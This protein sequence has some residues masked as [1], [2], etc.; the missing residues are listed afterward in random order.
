MVT[1]LNHEEMSQALRLCY[2][3]EQLSKNAGAFVRCPAV[4]WGDPGC[5]KTSLARALAVE[6]AEDFR[7]AGHESGFWATALALKNPEDIGGFPI[8]DKETW[9][10][11]FIP[12]ADLPFVRKDGTAPYGVWV[13]DDLDRAS[14]ETRNCAMSYLLDRT[15]NGND[16]SPNVYLC[17]T[18][19]GESDCGT[20]SPLGGAFGNRL[21][22]LYLRAAEGWSSH[23]KSRHI[24]SI[25]ALLPIKETEF[26]EV[27][28][29]TPRS[30]EM[31]K[32]I[33][34]ARRN[35]SPK[36]FRAVIDGCVGS[37][38]GCLISKAALRNICLEDILNSTAI[39]I[40][41]VTFD[42]MQMLCEELRMSVKPTARPTVKRIVTDWAKN[43]DG[44]LSRI[45]ISEIAD[46]DRETVA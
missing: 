44:E 40:D 41:K 28:M 36:V 21:V 26:T 14:T 38:A 31:A 8:P 42:D 3:A 12:P 24:K 37:E 27:A 45:V 22:H 46:W 2:R 7:K 17:G 13:I 34:E 30:L 11:R 10:M 15:A 33:I 35:E 16:I 43:V 1:Y 32:W 18:A 9:S 23:I 6:L 39:D 29:C 25:E 19:N 4:M 5:G 20:T